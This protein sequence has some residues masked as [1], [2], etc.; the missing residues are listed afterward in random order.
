MGDTCDGSLKF[1]IIFKVVFV[2]N[3]SLLVARII[4]DEGNEDAFIHATWR[5]GDDVAIAST[6]V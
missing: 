4:Q 3:M 6:F 5:F 1:L 2:L